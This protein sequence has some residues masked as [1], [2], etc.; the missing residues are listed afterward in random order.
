[1]AFLR[2]ER[3]QFVIHVLFVLD[4]GIPLTPFP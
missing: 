2:L 3:S 1:M 4:S